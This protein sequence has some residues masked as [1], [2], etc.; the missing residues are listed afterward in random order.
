MSIALDVSGSMSFIDGNDKKSR[1]TL[2]KESLKKLVSIMDPTK[3]KM[4]LVTFNHNSEKIFDLL[5]KNEIE[6]KFLNDIDSIKANGGTDLVGALR[7]A[8]NNINMENVEQKEKRIIMITDAAYRDVN[9]NLLNLFIQTMCR[10]KRCIYY[11]YSNKFRIK[12][13]I[14]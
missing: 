9:D 14:S 4:S 6:T 7:A 3:D 13:I 11:Y 10:R 5:D 8:M 12:F 2:A 1:I